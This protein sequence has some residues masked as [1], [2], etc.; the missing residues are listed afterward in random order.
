MGVKPLSQLRSQFLTITSTSNTD[1]QP[2]DLAG[3]VEAI[4]V[5]SE[6]SLSSGDLCNEPYALSARFPLLTA[7][8]PLITK[9]NDDRL[10]FVSA[11]GAASATV[12]IWIIRRG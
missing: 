6:D 12:S 1:Y 8:M 11:D 2:V 3:A 4:F 9:S 5:M 7:N 10:Y